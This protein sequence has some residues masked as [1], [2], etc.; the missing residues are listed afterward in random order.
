MRPGASFRDLNPG[1]PDL[2]A[3]ALS[4]GAMTSPE[5]SHRLP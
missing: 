4:S 3:L 2:P 5:G 1:S